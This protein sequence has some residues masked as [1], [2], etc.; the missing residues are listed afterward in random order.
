MPAWPYKPELNKAKA[1]FFAKCFMHCL[2]CEGIEVSEE[3][4]IWIIRFCNTVGEKDYLD[5][6]VARIA[7]AKREESDKNWQMI[8]EYM[9]K[10]REAEKNQ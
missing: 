7:E 1:V 4:S 6:T 10:K 9:R 5:S 8:D 2:E 3:E